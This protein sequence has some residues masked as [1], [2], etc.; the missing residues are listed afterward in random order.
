MTGSDET[1]SP[2]FAVI[3]AGGSGTRFW[4][5]SRQKR[6]KHLLDIFGGKS[7]LQQTIARLIPLIPPERILVVTAREHS[8]EVIRQSPELPGINIVSEPLGRNTAA[9][10]GLAAEHIRRRVT[11]AVMV[12]LPADQLI[13]DQESFRHTLAAAIETAR[14]NA[15]L[16]TIGIK[17]SAPETGYG[18]I[19]L[20]EIAQEVQGKKVYRVGAF[21]EKP[22]PRR[23]RE[24]LAR[25]DHLW[26]SGIFIW[27]VK[28]IR[29]EMEKSLPD[30]F[31]L[32]EEIGQS[33][34]TR[35]EAKTLKANYGKME[36]VSIDYGVMEKAKRVLV[37][38]GEFDWRDLGSWDAFWEFSEKDQEKNAVW[39][40]DSIVLDT[41][42]SLAVSPGKLVVLLG[43]ADL[44]VVENKDTLLICKRGR[45]QE[46]GKIPKLLAG[47]G[48]TKYL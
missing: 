27:Q 6:P 32:L 44:L 37:I 8:R 23:A 40:G 13:T 45:S 31:R 1:S 19:Q 5:Y 47:Q 36:P 41:T 24:F 17:P 35:Q 46:I 4:P 42:N 38:P 33:L 11:N 16:I 43:V 21:R 29:E 48:K 28:V 12:A 22:S 14:L 2:A 18:Y 39:A 7:L 25:G 3:M 26:N 34:G 30:L 10:I 9:C 20:A 15:S